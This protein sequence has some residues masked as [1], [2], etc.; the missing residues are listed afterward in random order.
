MDGRSEARLG[1][2]WQAWRGCIR[3][4]A[5]W[6]GGVGLGSARLGRLGRVWQ[7]MAGLGKARFG[8]LGSVSQGMV[9]HGLAG[10]GMPG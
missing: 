9:C 2:V 5:A 6:Q 1:N 4:G 8:R 7:G 3:H 10:L